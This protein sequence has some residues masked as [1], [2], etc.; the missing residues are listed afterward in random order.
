MNRKK[1]KKRY[2]FPQTCISPYKDKIEDAI[3]RKEH[4]GHRKPLFSHSLR[5]AAA[6]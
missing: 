5:G 1:K 2:G 3:L 6:Y 4:T